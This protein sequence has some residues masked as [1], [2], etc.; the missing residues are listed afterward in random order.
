MIGY[1]IEK[2]LESFEIIIDTREKSNSKAD[3][4]YNGFGCRYTKFALEV[5]D[6]CGNAI[7]PS[8]RHVIECGTKA[9]TPACAIERKMDINELVGCFVGRKNNSKMKWSE[10][11]KLSVGSFFFVRMQVGLISLRI[12]I[13]LK[14]IL[15]FY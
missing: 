9:I 3:R 10:R 14:W 13:D 11:L 6:Y 5:G 2:V 12:A 7:L 15:K 1:D 4:R 8:G